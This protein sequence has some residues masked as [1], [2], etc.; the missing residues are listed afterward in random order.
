MDGYEEWSESVDIKADR[1]N[2]L[3]A[4][5]LKPT[6]SI[7]IK[8]NPPEATIYLDGERVGTTP[9]ILKSVEIG[10]HEVEVKMEGFEEWKKTLKVKKGKEFALN[11]A[12]QLNTGSVNIEG[13]P[14]EIR[15][16][17]DG[18]DVGMTPVNLTGI[19][20]GIYDVELQK[21]GYVS[22]KKNFKSKSWPKKVLDCKTH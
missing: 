16:L 9:D 12:L 15:V 1:E 18:N 20:I 14:S 10:A 4:K 21:E 8:S 5:L 3:T 19:K 6:G 11:V 22:C 7:D 13:D 17:F 2:S